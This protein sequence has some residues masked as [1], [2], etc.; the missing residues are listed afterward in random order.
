MGKDLIRMEDAVLAHTS[1]GV[2]ALIA[3][4]GGGARYAYEEFFEGMLANEHT[5]KAYR[6][7][8]DRFLAHA[9]ELGLSLA[10]ITPKLLRAY[11]DKLPL[12]VASQKLHLAA[13]RHFFDVAVTRHAVML[14]PAASVRA[15]K[16]KVVEGKTPCATPEQAGKLLGSIDT[17]TVVGKRDLAVTATLIFTGAR[18]GA[19][20]K[21]RLADFYDGGDQHYLRFDEKGGKSREIPVRHDLQSYLKQY[22]AAALIAGEPPTAPLFRTAVQR[23]GTLS[24]KPVSAIDLCRMVKRR[25]KDADLPSRLSPHSFRVTV[26]TDLLSQDVPLDQVQQLLGHADPRTTRLYDRRQQ[27]VS[28]NIV[29]R[30]SVKI[31]EQSIYRR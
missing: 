3:E 7:A 2:P 31:N 9:H 23:T 24:P 16:L 21:L 28:R 18:V 25:L 1:A 8:V 20:A 15:K 10:Q 26:A 5:R 13:L 27:K 12:S 17:A 29:E 11:L 30:I 4:G 19:V 6:R 14:N 22:I